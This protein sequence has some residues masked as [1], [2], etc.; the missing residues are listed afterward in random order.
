MKQ[1]GKPAKSFTAILQKQEENKKRKLN[2]NTLRNN[3]CTRRA[4]QVSFQ[5]L[6]RCSCAAE[7]AIPYTPIHES[8]VGPVLTGKV[9]RPDLS[10]IFK[11]TSTTTFIRAQ[12]NN[13][14]EPTGQQTNGGHSLTRRDTDTKQD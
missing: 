3:E 11:A 13:D 5:N 2:T 7:T 9:L 4:H 14:V 1:R 10:A 8:I 12:T 6:G